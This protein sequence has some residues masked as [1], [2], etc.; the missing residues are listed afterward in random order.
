MIAIVS[1]TGV[2]DIDVD[3]PLLTTALDAAGVTHTTVAWDDPDVEWDRFDLAVIRSTW[4]YVDR[5]DDYLAWAERAGAA[6]LLLNPVDVVRWN[7]DKRYL[8]ELAGAGFAVTPTTFL[9]PGDTV[10]GFDVPPHGVVV[11]PCVSAGSKDTARHLERAAARAHALGLLDDGRAVMVQPYQHRIDEVGET[12]LVF[13]EGSY[14]HAFRKGP[15]LS[16]PREVVGGLFV[17]EQIDARDPTAGER[18]LAE[19][20]VEWVHARFGRLL[21]TRVDV[22]PGDD[23]PVVLELELVEPSLFLTQHE[24]AAATVAGAIAGRLAAARR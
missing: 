13:V 4:D 11:K 2:A 17:Q 24:P 20:V 16:A 23:G 8:R 1:S 6:T 14:S 7:I 12:G 18:A 21:Y 22:V 3:Q 9:E 15:I 19:A 10:G 5:L